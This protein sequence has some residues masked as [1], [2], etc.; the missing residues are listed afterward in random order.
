MANVIPTE[1]GYGQILG[2]PPRPEPPRE[3][4]TADYLSLDETRALFVDDEAFAEALADGGFPVPCYQTAKPF[5][6][7]GAIAF[8]SGGSY[9]SR[10]AV[11]VWMEDVRRRA[12]WLR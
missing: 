1:Y 5:N 12:A 10:R 3:S 9:R 11:A 8:K 6:F 7:L 2:A 4:P